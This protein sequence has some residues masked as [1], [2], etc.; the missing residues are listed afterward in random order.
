M[1]AAHNRSEEGAMR[2]F[3]RHWIARR[4]DQLLE[5]A[6][7]GSDNLEYLAHDPK[8]ADSELCTVCGRPWR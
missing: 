7:L 5:T 1:C 4:A 8:A 3:W 2:A 6:P